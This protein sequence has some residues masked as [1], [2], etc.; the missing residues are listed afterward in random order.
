MSI[1]ASAEVVLKLFNLTFGRH[2][3]DREL[4]GRLCDGT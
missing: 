2:C 3:A 4:R 1:E